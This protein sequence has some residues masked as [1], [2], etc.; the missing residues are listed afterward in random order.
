[1]REGGRGGGDDVRERTHL[2]NG[3]IMPNEAELVFQDE[4]FGSL[5]PIGWIMLVLLYPIHCAM[6]S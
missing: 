4:T 1:M 3:S 5:C 2:A 6:N